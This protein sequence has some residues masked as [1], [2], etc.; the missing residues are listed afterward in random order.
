MKNFNQ[1]ALADV[2][3]VAE[4]LSKNPIVSVIITQ[5]EENATIK[6]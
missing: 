2:Q 3:R 1:V 4:R 5:T 6:N